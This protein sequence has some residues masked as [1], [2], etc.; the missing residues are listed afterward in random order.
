MCRT[1][2]YTVTDPRPNVVLAALIREAYPHEGEGERKAE[3]EGAE[4]GGRG[5]AGGE[6]EAGAEGGA[7]DSRVLPLFLSSSVQLPAGSCSMHLFEPR[8]R[9][10]VQ[11]AL[12]G[13]GDFAMVWA[14]EGRGFPMH[15][16]PGSLQGTVCCVAH[17]ERSRQTPDGRWNLACRGVV[18]AEIKD[19]WVEEGTGELY[20]ARV[21]PLQ[22]EDAPPH[23]EAPSAVDAA[24]VAGPVGESAPQPSQGDST[25]SSAVAAAVEQPQLPD[26]V[27]SSRQERLEY[28]KMIMRRLG[29]SPEQALG[30]LA[31]SESA[32]QDNSSQ[33]RSVAKAVWQAAA[34]LGVPPYGWVSDADLQA[35]LEAPSLDHR[36]SK[37]C[38]LYHDAWQQRWSVTSWVSFGLRRWGPLLVALFIAWVA[39]AA[40]DWRQ[41]FY[42]L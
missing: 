4:A 25:S 17:I 42:F 23:A 34:A 13:G 20:I 27:G 16:A 1:T 40:K 2:C 28:I 19:C 9:I 39:S 11:R 37:L 5:A 26:E 18:K 33:A 7:E 38:L 31:G 30:E 21:R 36:I 8:Y 41:Y 32:G 3:G 29:L 22:D 35:L 6:A 15:V 10:L 12:D 14:R 24:S